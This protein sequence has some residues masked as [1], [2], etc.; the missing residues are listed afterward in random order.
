MSRN[1]KKLHLN[2]LDV[3]SDRKRLFELLEIV[4]DYKKKTL[5][6]FCYRKIHKQV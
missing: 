1:M 4:K 6:N 5:I 3:F 2:I